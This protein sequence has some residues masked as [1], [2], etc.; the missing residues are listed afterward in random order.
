M[1]LQNFTGYSNATKV[2]PLLKIYG[3]SGMTIAT[4]QQFKQARNKLGLSAKQLGTILNTDPR[5]IRRWED[6][7]GTRPP[8][9]VACRVMEWLLTGWRPPEYPENT[10]K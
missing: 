10:A 9:P 2:S 3:Q 1:D 6:E 5:T 4:P 7:S 8:N